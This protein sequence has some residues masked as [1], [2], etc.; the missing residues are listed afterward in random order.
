M[1]NGT[2]SSGHLICTQDS[3]R[4]GIPDSPPVSFEAVGTDFF[5]GRVTVL[6]AARRCKRKTRS[7]RV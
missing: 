5:E 1:G 4:V 6:M 3:S 2:A 7:I